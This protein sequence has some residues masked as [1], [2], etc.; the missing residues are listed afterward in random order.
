M[1]QVDQRC[2][3]ESGTSSSLLHAPS[4]QV[5]QEWKILLLDMVLRLAMSVHCLEALK[6]CTLR[7]CDLATLKYLLDCL[8]LIMTV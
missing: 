5:A 4:H 2:T 3:L 1:D 8:M 7:E 6:I